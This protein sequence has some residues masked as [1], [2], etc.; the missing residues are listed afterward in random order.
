MTDI[1]LQRNRFFNLDS[2]FLV[3]AGE[4]KEVKPILQ[5]TFGNNTFCQVETVFRFGQM[6]APSGG[7]EGTRLRLRNNLFTH[8][9]ALVR[10]NEQQVESTKVRELFSTLLG[11]V[12]EPAAC[13]EG[14]FFNELRPLTID[15]PLSTETGD[16]TFLLYPPTSPLRSAGTDKGPVG[17]PPR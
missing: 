4:N 8:T 12:R 11:N 5:M 10:T 13:Q 17:V 9:T 1:D 15:P 14:I 6:P 2:A 7:D 16:H 3:R